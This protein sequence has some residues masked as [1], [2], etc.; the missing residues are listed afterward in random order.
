MFDLLSV[1]LLIKCAVL[2]CL[3]AL[4]N[5]N[6]KHFVNLIKFALVHV[7]VLEKLCN[8]L[9]DEVVNL[10]LTNI[11]DTEFIAELVNKQNA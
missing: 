2:D 11:V 6:F 7:A 5:L 1:W 3:S 9:F 10:W 4:S 8:L